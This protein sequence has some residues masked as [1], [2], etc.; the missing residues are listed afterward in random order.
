MAKRRRRRARLGDG[1]ITR[2]DKLRRLVK[3][4]MFV[5]AGVVVVG[6]AYVAFGGAL[7]KTPTVAGI[8]PENVKLAA[9][10]AAARGL[11]L[12]WVLATILVESG[13]NPNT[14]GDY[15]IDPKGASIGLMQ[16][17]SVAHAAELAAAGL[18][19][20]SLFNPDTNIEWGTKI[21]RA[22]FDR[23]RGLG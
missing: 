4:L 12:D 11:P 16:I 3:P 15:H 2:R 10:W 5:G 6:L 13:G 23:V 18:T 8:S 19:R 7:K 1:E 22:C 9:K 20:E 17:N 14:V 21:L